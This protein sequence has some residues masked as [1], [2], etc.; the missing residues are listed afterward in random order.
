MEER[1]ALMPALREVSRRGALLPE[2]DSVG[3]EL[4]SVYEIHR[5]CRNN[6]AARL[7][8]TALDVLK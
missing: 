7:R 5:E 4:K 2:D 1:A 6:A 8:T 3:Q